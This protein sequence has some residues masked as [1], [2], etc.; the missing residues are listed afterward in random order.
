LKL[1][2]KK[3]KVSAIFSD[4]DG[5]LVPLTRTKNENSIP[6]ELEQV[7]DKI[8]TEIPVCI[9]STKDFEFLRKRT[10]FARVLSCIMGIE[11]IVLGRDKLKSTIERR[12]LSADLE[13]LELNSE[14]LESI[15][16]E[17]KS[18]EDLSQVLV[19]H[20]HTSD[21]V[22]AGL[23]IDWRNLGNWPHY[24]T[25]VS[26]VVSKTVAALEKPPVPISI[27]MQKYSTHPFI[28]LYG[29]QCSKDMAFDA[30]ISELADAS[31]DG[32]QTVYLGD[33]EN[34]NPAFRKAGVSIGIRSDAR[35]NPKLDCS[36]LLDYEELPSFLMKLRQN[37]YIFTDEFLVGGKA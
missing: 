13:V 3:R 1:Q 6:K 31:V 22:L 28:D 18:H 4:Y 16:E 23:T 12:N 37:D 34:D 25:S 5:T 36:Y 11:T 24:A 14:A 7:L 35:L 32:R 10:N 17:V 8:S 26:H 19:E 9:V 33:S 30:V 2:N 29:V 20:K 27:F 21:G 15:A